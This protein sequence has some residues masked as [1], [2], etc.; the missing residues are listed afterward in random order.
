MRISTI[1]IYNPQIKNYKTNKQQ[2]TS[3]IS[4]DGN[5]L[6]NQVSFRRAFKRFGRCSFLVK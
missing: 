5:K 2:C 6:N 4:A 3:G 1:Q